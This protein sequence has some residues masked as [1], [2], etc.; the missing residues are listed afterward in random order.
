MTSREAM[1]ISCSPV[2]GTIRVDLGS[3]GMQTP[4]RQ[5]ACRLGSPRA[6]SPWNSTWHTVGPQQTSREL[7]GRDASVISLSCPCSPLNS[8]ETQFIST[9]KWE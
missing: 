3:N 8:I 6:S 1:G 7:T 5:D 9:W 4:C 2:A